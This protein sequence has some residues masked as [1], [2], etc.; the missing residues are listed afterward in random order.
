M[1]SSPKSVLVY[2]GLQRCP[3]REGQVARMPLYRQL[4]AL[5]LEETD[6]H[7]AQAER[8]VGTCLYRTACPTCR[9]C[10][11][12]RIPVDEFR[13]TR[14]QRRVLARWQDRNRIEIGPA[15]YTEEKLALFNRHK[16]R[17]GLVAADDDGE[18]TALGY[19]SWLVQTCTLTVEMRYFHDDV[20]VGV[21]LVDLGRES[22]SSV[23][24]YFDPDR[25]DL[26]PGVF[27]VLSEID[28]CR[29]T[30]RRWLYLGL[31]V[32]DCRHL[33]YKARY[34]PHERLVDG[35]WRRFASS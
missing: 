4:R 13:P 22:A 11:G 14:D 28:L 24:F 35:D 23:Y 16:Q 34:R 21:G 17:R 18:M 33:S 19:S 5:T 12:L 10:E 15:T 30:G 9:A 8:R 2:D 29:R 27:S 6:G 1:R 20:L 32:E 25:S 31:Y 26:S 7:L 3:Y